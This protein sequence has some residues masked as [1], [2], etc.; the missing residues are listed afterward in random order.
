MPLIHRVSLDIFADYHQFYLADGGMKWEIPIDW[1]DKDIQNGALVTDSVIA[2]SPAR[3]MTVPVDIELYDQPQ[4]I[5][6][7]NVDHA[8][9]CSL[10]LPTGHLQVQECAGPERCYLTVPNGIY[11]VHVLFSK[12][13]E[14]SEDGLEGKDQYK[15]LLWPGSRQPLNVLKQWQGN[16][17]G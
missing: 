6:L 14:I 5:D 2:V 4:E 9:T 16:W 17:R 15:I 10:E 12:L 11:T 8:F 3:N 13:A 1:T 7:Q